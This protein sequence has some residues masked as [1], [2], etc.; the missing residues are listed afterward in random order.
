VVVQDQEDR[1]VGVGDQ[2]LGEG[3]EDL[4]V[5]AALDDHEAQGTLA[6]HR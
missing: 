6:G 2:A 1:A 5:D 4:R 3:E